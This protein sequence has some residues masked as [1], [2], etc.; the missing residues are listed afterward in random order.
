MRLTVGIMAS[1][2]FAVVREACP[3]CKGKRGYREAVF[4]HAPY[5]HENEEI[6]PCGEGAWIDCTL[7]RGAGDVHPQDVGVAVWRA[8]GGDAPL[9]LRGFA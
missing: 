7:C 6:D 8:R 1:D 9:Q 3:R 5:E 2:D 4:C